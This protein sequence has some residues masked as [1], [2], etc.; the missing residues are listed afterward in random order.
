[1]FAIRRK[2]YRPM[3]NGNDLPFELFREHADSFGPIV[4]NFGHH[5]LYCLI[6]DPVKRDNCSCCEIDVSHIQRPDTTNEQRRSL[7]C[8]WSNW[9]GLGIRPALHSRIVS[10]K[11]ISEFAAIGMMSLLIIKLERLIIDEILPE[12][13][14]IG[15]DYV[16]KA[17][18]Q[19]ERFRI[20]VSGIRIAHHNYESETRL[21][22]KRERLL[23]FNNQGFVS[24]T[25]F[26]HP[27]D[28]NIYSI[29]HFVK[30]PGKK[31]KRNKVVKISREN[32]ARKASILSMEGETALGN[33]DIILVREKHTQAAKIL[34]KQLNGTRNRAERQLRLFLVA[35]QYFK[36]GLYKRARK[37]VRRVEPQFFPE[38]DKHLFQDFR[39]QVRRRLKRN[40][41][42]D[43]RKLV[44][45]YQKRDDFRKVAAV[46]C[47]HP[48]AYDRIA[49]AFIQAYTSMRS[50]NYSAAGIFASAVCEFSQNDPFLTIQMAFL[51][52]LIEQTDSLEGS[53]LAA[54]IFAKYFK[55]PLV[56]LVASSILYRLANSATGEK[57][58]EWAH[59]QIEYYEK[60]TSEFNNLKNGFQKDD[61]ARDFLFISAVTAAIAYSWMGE[62]GKASVALESAENMPYERRAHYGLIDGVRNL[63]ASSSGGDSIDFESPFSPQ[64]FEKII[65]EIK[66][67]T[68]KEMDSRTAVAV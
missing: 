51:P 33:A 27:P 38:Y 3:T 64:E 30:K 56:N 63:I 14:G 8:D 9:E 24:V 58:R 43:I 26:S 23:Q 65:A 12:S 53:W 17:T 62:L 46:V 47:H 22:Q 66:A 49:L 45:Y 36:A 55:H 54:Q 16:I 39:N 5:L 52:G 25:A 11:R 32:P 13:S 42:I 57:R 44:D 19:Q 18:D 61:E 29:L 37:Y 41:E 34:R 10:E 48:F 15:A 4:T 21:A 40:Y 60:A 2:G 1:M 6:V 7:T 59:K 31:S 20:E 28:G 67:R 50:N 68:N 35:T